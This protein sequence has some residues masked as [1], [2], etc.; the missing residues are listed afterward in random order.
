VKRLVVVI[1][2]MVGLLLAACSQ[3]PT[4]SLTS[5]ALTWQELPATGGSSFSAADI[6]RKSNNTPVIAFAESS[7]SGTNTNLI[8]REWNGSAWQNLGEAL[9]RRLLNGVSQP[10]IAMMSNDRPVVVWVE[11]SPS[12]LNGSL[13]VKRW[14]GTSW[15]AIGSGL[16]KVTANA[17]QNPAITLDATNSPI[18]AWEEFDGAGYNI[19]VKRRVGAT[20]VFLGDA[21]ARGYGASIAFDKTT[22]D[23]I[24]AYSTNATLAGD[25]G[26]VFVKKWNGTAWVDYGTGQALNRSLTRSASFPSLAL[27]AR[28]FPTVA[29]VEDSIQVKR[30]NGSRWVLVGNEPYQ[31]APNRASFP[32][33]SLR[34][35]G[36]PVVVWSN[37]N[38]SSTFIL[39]KEWNAATR[40]WVRLEPL[41]LNINVG[42]DIG[43]F[44]AITLKTD[45]RPFV[46]WKNRTAG[47]SAGNII[48]KEYLDVPAQ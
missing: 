43:E 10:A 26:K 20:W 35:D 29:W 47:N 8:V 13:F 25:T 21:V 39:V 19:Y 38:G 44:P 11:R 22:G 32:D 5:Q 48:V 27:D 34:S 3:T 40:Q 45:N 2:G 6:T 37:F 17:A 33:L 46:V 31:S 42:G 9:D 1:F 28:G 41:P 15:Q 18:V 4:G 36:R 30:W 7:S 14:S 24:L 12:S 23:I 16:D